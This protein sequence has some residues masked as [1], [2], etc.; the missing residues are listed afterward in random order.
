[1]AKKKCKCELKDKRWETELR[2]RTKTGYKMDRYCKQ[3]GGVV[4]EDVPPKSFE[5]FIRAWAHNKLVDIKS[6]NNYYVDYEGRLKY[7][8]VTDGGKDTLAIRLEDGRI[9]GNAQKM[10]SCGSML[11]QIEAPAQQVMMD[12]KIA[13]VPF[14]VFKEAD[15]NIM[16][17]K[18]VCQG[19]SEILMSPKL[20][21]KLP[22]SSHERVRWVPVP[23][24]ETKYCS[25][26]RLKKCDN[27]GQGYNGK[28]QCRG[29]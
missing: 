27:K 8:S 16:N 23:L 25:E 11:S 10:N 1:M 13:M 20:R 12:L 6:C 18:V 26:K 5:G 21:K 19:E 24:Y 14:N 17:A 28:E 7:E 22:R 15:L 3:C 9:L 29:H 4:D 2:A